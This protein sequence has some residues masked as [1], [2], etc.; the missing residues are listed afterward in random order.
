MRHQ[1]SKKVT[2]WV[3]QGLEYGYPDC[4]I[5]E[6]VADI[7]TSRFEGRE[8]QLRGSGY[9]PCE[10]CNKRNTAIQ[11][12]KVVNERREENLPPFGGNNG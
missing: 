7:L 11:L 6:F 4:C 12:I 10:T 5:G 2:E 3:L 1:H 8:R 9:V